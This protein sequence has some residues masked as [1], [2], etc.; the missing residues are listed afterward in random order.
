MSDREEREEIRRLI[1]MAK[2]LFVV[3][4]ALIIVELMSCTQ[5][6]KAATITGDTPLAGI[7]LARQQI[8]DRGLTL[9]EIEDARLLAEVMYHE[10]WN[11][12][13]ARKAAYYTGA[14]VLNRVQHKGFPNTIKGVLFQKGQ[15]ITTKKFFS[16]ELPAECYELAIDLLKHG[17]PEVPRAVIYQSTH[18]EFGS[19]VWREINGEFFNY[20]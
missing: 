1:N 7:S 15:Y 8:I 18:R 5:E 19:G 16:V 10:N 6:A 20:E 17:A 9:P 12:D 2:L 4:I 3:M 11:T 14:V 13:K